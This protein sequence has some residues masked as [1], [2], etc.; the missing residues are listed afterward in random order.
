MRVVISADLFRTQPGQRHDH[1]KN[2]NDRRRLNTGKAPIDS[3][4][5]VKR[6]ANSFDFPFNA[7]NSKAH[8]KTQSKAMCD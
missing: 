3:F 7:G 4:S 8:H 6:R 5:R 1:Y 2:L